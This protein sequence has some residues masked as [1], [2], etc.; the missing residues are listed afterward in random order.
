MMANKQDLPQAGTVGLLTEALGLRDVTDRQWLLQ[1]TVAYTAQGL[2]EGCDWL[3]G[4][5]LG[6]RS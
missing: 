1:P 4:R 3:V 5:V 2:Y 6:R